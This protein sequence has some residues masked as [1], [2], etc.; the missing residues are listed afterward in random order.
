MKVLVT[1]GMGF[2]GSYLV[3]YLVTN[4]DEV[5]VLDDL[6]GVKSRSKFPKEV[7]KFNLTV[8][9]ILDEKLVTGLMKKVSVC[10]HL[11][12]SLGVE[13]INQDPF[14]AFEV[15]FKGS[16]I[17]LKAAAYFGVRTL[18]ASSSEVYG[19]NC[20]VPLSED[21]DRILGQTNI[22]RWSYSEA[23]ALDELFAFE[24]YRN[25]SFPVSIAR[26]FNTVGPNQNGTYGMVLPRFINSALNNDP[27][28]VY[29]DG[30]QSRSFCSVKDVIEAIVLLMKT[31]N[32]IGQAYNIGSTNEITIQGLA[33]KVLKL[34][35]SN[36]EIKHKSYQEIF[37]KNFEEPYRRFPD[38]SKI[39]KVVGWKPKIT[40]DEIISD[41]AEYLR[42]HEA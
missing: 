30:K 16:E 4:G 12:A 21:A 20:M 33:L 14:S 42:A 23:K 2:I 13:K 5:Y 38:I 11:A 35:N 15:N 19:K 29:G 28:I 36:S 3:E 34:T 7:E 27:I 25:E 32:C 22:N 18:V 40:L 1:G 9:S 37:G 41:I 24:L 10:Y 26:F 31:P 6:S 17:V 8:G 39:N